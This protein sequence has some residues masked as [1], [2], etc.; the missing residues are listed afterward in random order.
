MKLNHQAARNHRYVHDP[1]SN[2]NE[3][4]S[5]G[6]STRYLH[7]DTSVV[8][9]ALDNVHCCRRSVG[10]QHKQRQ[11]GR[12]TVYATGTPACC[13]LTEVAA[14]RTR[15]VNTRTRKQSYLGRE[16]LARYGET[17]ESNSAPLAHTSRRNRPRETVSSNWSNSSPTQTA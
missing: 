15:R 4:F 2:A 1:P 13:H 12:V 3:T 17:V 16:P 8:H 7:T 5:R 14:A 9:P 11:F 6:E 10:V